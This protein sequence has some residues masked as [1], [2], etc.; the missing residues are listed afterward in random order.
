M[1]MLETPNMTAGTELLLKL[2]SMKDFHIFAHV[3]LPIDFL[4]DTM[5]T[6]KRNSEEVRSS[7][8]LFY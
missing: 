6:A 2:D 5:I 4:Q 1:A 7:I 3:A 8:F